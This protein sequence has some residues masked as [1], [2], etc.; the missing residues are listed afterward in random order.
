MKF[1]QK[2]K[3]NYGFVTICTLGKLEQEK[4]VWKLDTPV[5][6]KIWQNYSEKII[7]E[8]FKL[9]LK[10]ITLEQEH[11]NKIHEFD[12]TW[13]GIPLIGDGMWTKSEN[14][15]LL[16]RTAD[17]IPVFIF[18]KKIPFIANLHSGWKGTQLGITESM[19]DYLNLQGFELQD[20][21]IHL[22]PY[23]A[24]PNYEVKW[25]VAKEFVS[26]GETVVSHNE[27]NSESYLLDTGF[28][29]EK[30]V[31]QKFPNLKVESSRLD[32][33][34]SPHFYSH[35]AKESGRNLNLIFWES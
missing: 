12:Q 34:K 22:G 20:F 25:D 24:K 17:C 3:T 7:K 33:Y 27:I 4:S 29:L 14:V 9:P 26:L 13:E 31:N 21:H 1:C 11:G 15:G 35:R 32:V 16:I 5:S 30:K 28:A 8:H 2:F 19:L 10:V 6:P 18:S 23:I